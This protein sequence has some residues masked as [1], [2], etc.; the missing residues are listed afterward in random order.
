M[1]VTLGEIVSAEKALK[2]IAKRAMPVKASYS[3]GRICRTVG[4]EL[5]LWYEERDK[6]IKELGL[7][8]GEQIT[9][10]DANM[11]EYVRR[12]NELASVEV[13]LDCEPLDLSM[14]PATFELSPA[15]LMLLGQFVVMA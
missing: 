6:S 2:D 11:G 10:T 8:Q 4:K 9:V 13:T 12:L 14:L 3:V 5:E 1:K 7:Q 15:D